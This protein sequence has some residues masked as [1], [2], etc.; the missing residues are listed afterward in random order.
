MMLAPARKKAGG[1]AKA[2][3]APAPAAAEAA[4]N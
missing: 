3:E 2:A 4:Q 1:A